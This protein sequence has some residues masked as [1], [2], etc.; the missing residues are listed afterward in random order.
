M[1]LHFDR[2]GPVEEEGGSHARG[3]RPDLGGWEDRGQTSSSRI[4]KELT[5]KK[6]GEIDGYL[7]LI[8]I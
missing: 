8:H 3:R 1:E 2:T 7:S 6:W 5:P 4:S